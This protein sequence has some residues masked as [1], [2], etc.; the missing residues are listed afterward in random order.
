MRAIGLLVVEIILEIPRPAIHGL[1]LRYVLAPLCPRS[2]AL[3]LRT[4]FQLLHRSRGERLDLV[5]RRLIST[6]RVE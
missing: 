6:N 1:L 4:S 3:S 2:V 5:F